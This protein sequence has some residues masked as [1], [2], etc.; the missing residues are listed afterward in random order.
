MGHPI[1]FSYQFTIN[2]DHSNIQTAG[3][4]NLSFTLKD[5]VST[6]LEGPSNSRCLTSQLAF[7]AC[8]NKVTS[9]CD[10]LWYIITPMLSTCTDAIRKAN[11]LSTFQKKMPC[12]LTLSYLKQISTRWLL[13]ILTRLKFRNIRCFRNLASSVVMCNV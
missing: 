9:T 8:Q 2:G 3:G 6:S 12:L 7:I 4:L 11:A 10:S 5:E 13:R 1:I